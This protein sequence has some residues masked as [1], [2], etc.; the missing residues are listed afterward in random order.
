MGIC[1][2]SEKADVAVA[3]LNEVEKSYER[4]IG[5][6]TGLLL[7]VYTVMPV[8]AKINQNF[9]VLLN[10]FIQTNP[11]SKSRCREWQRYLFFVERTGYF[12]I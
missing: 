3:E 5:S 8:S 1:D 6:H 11:V 7:Y 12:L 4:I 10:S 9:G 2:L